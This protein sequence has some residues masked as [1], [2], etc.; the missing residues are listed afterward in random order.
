MDMIREME[1][2]LLAFGSGPTLEEMPRNSLAD[3]GIA[4]PTAAHRIEE[5]HTPLN[6]AYI[7]CTTG[8]TAF[9]NIVG[10]TRQELPARIAAGILALQRCGLKPGDQIIITYP[11]LVNVFSRS[12]LDEFGAEVHFIQ[13]PSRDA[14]LVSLCTLHPRAVIGESSFL[15]AAIEDARRLNI[16]DDLPRNLIFIA[17]GSPLDTE[18]ADAI[19]P[20]PGAVLHDLY[21][22]QEFGW[23]ALDGVPLRNDLILWDADGKKRQLHLLAGGIPTGDC[24]PAGRHPL[25]AEG[26]IVTPCRIRMESEPET[27]ILAAAAADRSTILRAVRTILRIKGRVLRV[28]P[29]LHCKAEATKL[30]VSMPSTDFA[31]TLQGPEETRLLDD[32]ISAQ[33]AYQREAKTDPVWNKSC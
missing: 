19:A 31:L 22:C 20:L 13:R 17:A 30:R 25:N 3:K 2:A 16:Q 15:R 26:T 12:A 28:S 5:I 24:F 14:L 29:D 21:G 33:C 6:L 7:T 18:L 23:L 10:V 4:G 1:Q 11:P 32:L 27:T 9:Q 8:T